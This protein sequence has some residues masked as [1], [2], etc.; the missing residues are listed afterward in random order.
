MADTTAEARQQVADRAAAGRRGDSTA[1]RRQRARHSTSRPRCAAS[2]R[3][4]RRRAAARPSCCWAARDAWLKAVERRLLPIVP[5][6][7]RRCCRRTIDKTI[8]RLP[9]G[10]REQV[11]AHLERDFATYLE[12]THPKDQPDARQ[13]FWKTYDVL[14]GSVGCSGQPAAGQEVARAV[15]QEEGQP[16]GLARL[17]RRPRVGSRSQERGYHRRPGEWWNGRHASLRS[18][19][20][21]SD[22]SVRIRPCPLSLAAERSLAV[23]RLRQARHVDDTADVEAFVRDPGLGQ[24]PV[25]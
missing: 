1:W 17:R 25:V 2:R 9:A 21:V 18:W 11:R 16:T 23:D 6:A 8:N 12:N 24:R 22:V 4:R 5:T 7:R 19:C 10:D 13:S 3:D 15:G 14:M 20:R